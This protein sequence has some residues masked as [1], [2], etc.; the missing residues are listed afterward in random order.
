MVNLHPTR[1]D[2]YLLGFLVG[3][4][5]AEPGC[6]GHLLRRGGLLC[7][8]LLRKPLDGVVPPHL[9]VRLL[10]HEINLDAGRWR[11]QVADDLHSRRHVPGQLMVGHVVPDAE[12]VPVDGPG[13][14]ALGQHRV[15]VRR[16][17]KRDGTC[18]YAQHK[19]QEHV[20]SACQTRRH[21]TNRKSLLLGSAA[22]SGKTF[23]RRPTIGNTTTDSIDSNNNNKKSNNKEKN[24][25][26]VNKK[27]E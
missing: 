8:R 12:L 20:M 10:G 15:H 2:S 23:L 11:A 6:V 18:C 22:R 9:H 25:T 24:I 4:H 14:V 5:L 17:R 19:Y 16:R 13:V 27:T 1:W 26:I 21:D 7:R 3:D